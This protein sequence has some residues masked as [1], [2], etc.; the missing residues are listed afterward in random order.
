MKVRKVIRAI[1]D[2]L[3]QMSAEDIAESEI[4]KNLLSENLPNSIR[5]AHS[6]KQE[7]ATIFEINASECYVEIHR[8]QWVNALQTIISWHSD[9][10]VQDYE[11][12]VELRKLIEAIT[13]INTTSK[14][15]KPKTKRGGKTRVQP[16][17]GRGEQDA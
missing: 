6:T 16:S 10:K 3:D 1:F 8:S 13:V 14:E 15:Q 5:R 7:Y 17:Q 9:E 12:C 11:K 2:N 4:L